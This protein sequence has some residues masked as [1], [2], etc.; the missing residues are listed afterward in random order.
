M[1]KWLN[2]MRQK[3][4]VEKQSFALFGAFLITL[5]IFSVWIFGII[6]SFQNQGSGPETSS[7]IQAIKSQISSFFDGKEVYES[8]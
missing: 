7:P 3:G 2:K 5:V 8:E 4:D 1:E 6:Y